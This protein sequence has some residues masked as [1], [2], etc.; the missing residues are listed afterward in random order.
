MSNQIFLNGAPVVGFGDAG[1]GVPT[2]LIAAPIIGLPFAVV[3]AGVGYLIKR[4]R[5]AIWGAVIGE[6]LG[7]ALGYGIGRGGM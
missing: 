1:S 6:V 2:A 5:G 3:G 4:G 7:G